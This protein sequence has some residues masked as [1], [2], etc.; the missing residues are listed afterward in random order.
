MNIKFYL[1]EKPRNPMLPPLKKRRW[2]QRQWRRFARVFE[3]LLVACLLVVP[4]SLWW[5]L[6][7]AGAFAA[8]WLG[9]AMVEVTDRTIPGPSAQSIRI[10]QT[11][12][13]WREVDWRSQ[14]QREDALR[15]WRL[16][17]ERQAV[18]AEDAYTVSL[19]V[20]GLMARDVQ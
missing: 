7:A 9:R 2:E 10:R 17:H 16:Y 5:L 1:V 3:T 18:E 11:Y 15:A 14:R 12:E 8:A 13:S 19:T 4:L 20:N 6:P